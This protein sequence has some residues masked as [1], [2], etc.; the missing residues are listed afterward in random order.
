MRKNKYIF[1]FLLLCPI[2]LYA[3]VQLPKYWGSGMVLQQQSAI[4]IIGKANRSTTVKISCSWSENIITSQ[5]DEYGVWNGVIQTPKG[6]NTPFQIL[7]CDGDSVVINNVLIGEVWLCSGQSNMFMPM[8]GMNKEEIVENGQKFI[9]AADI[10][11]PL[12]LFTVSRKASSEPLD[13]ISEGVWCLNA[14]QHVAKF[15]ATA[16]F[17]GLYLQKQL[18]VP[19][20]LVQSAWSG[21][22]I[23]S[24][25]SRESV[26]NFPKVKLSTIPDAE[27]K[28]LNKTPTLLYNG[29]IAPLKNI[30]FKGVIWYQGEANRNDPT[31]YESYFNEM[32]KQWRSHF[33]QPD[34]PIYYVELAPFQE[35]NVMD[36]KLPVFWEVQMNILK[37]TPHVGMAFTNDLGDLKYI[38][39]PRKQEVGERLAY[40]ALNK[41]YGRTEIACY[42]PVFNSLK[43]VGKKVIV[44]FNYTYKGLKSTQEKLIG[45]EMSDQNGIIKEAQAKIIKG[46]SKVEVWCDEVPNPTQIRYCFRNYLIGSLFNSEGLPAASFRASVH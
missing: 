15:S 39:A 25:M 37:K 5:S 18:N 41:T 32:S 6:N 21:S 42:G 4:N 19:V 2:S 17:F 27:N 1:F 38:H 34:L 43:R 33:N 40:C 16:Y 24:W 10:N 3:K 20:G 30:R 44:D 46:T 14:P 9:D 28:R 35:G 36:E 12:R 45:F 11:Q 8:V 22:G 13:D 7:F 29:M 26:L 31:T 23:T